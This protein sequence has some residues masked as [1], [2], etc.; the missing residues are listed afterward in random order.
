[1]WVMLHFFKTAVSKLVKRLQ[2]MVS[3]L[4]FIQ[5]LVPISKDLK[6]HKPFI[7]N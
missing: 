1:M 3:L 4:A 5:E 6:L 2:N 7:F